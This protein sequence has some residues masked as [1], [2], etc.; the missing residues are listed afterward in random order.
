MS[1]PQPEHRKLDHLYDLVR[2]FWKAF[3]G[4]S[5]E[6]DRWAYRHYGRGMRQDE[7]QKKDGD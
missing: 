5:A 6:L 2:I 3:R 4:I 7:I 1:K